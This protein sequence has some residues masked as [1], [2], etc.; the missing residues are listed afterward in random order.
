MVG[1]WRLWM[2]AGIVALGAGAALACGSGTAHADSAGP[3]SSAADHHQKRTSGPAVRSHS[4][5]AAGH[6]VTA[7]RGSAKAASRSVVGRANAE[8]DNAIADQD[9]EIAELEKAITEQQKDFAEDLREVVTTTNFS[10]F[11]PEVNSTRIY[12]G[13]SS[14]ALINAASVWNGL[15]DELNAAA[16]G[17][18]R[19]SKVFDSAPWAGPA[20]SAMATAVTPYVGWLTAAAAQAESAASQASVVASAFEAAFVG[21]ATPPVIAVNRATL[22]QLTA[23]NLFSGNVPAIAATEAM[24]AGMWAQDVAALVGYHSGSAPV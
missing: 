3:A 22:I 21:N 23:A 5:P 12:T 13:A 24:Y 14:A 2:G 19:V 1:E 16:Q 9:K 4:T 7:P 8:G 11:P 6:V 15:A 20:S 10:V 18:D 17:F